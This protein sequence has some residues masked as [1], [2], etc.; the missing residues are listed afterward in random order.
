MRIPK[1]DTSAV[2]IDVQEKLFP[3]IHEKEALLKKL[4]TLIKGVSL[5]HIPLQVTEQYPE[6]LGATIP[7][8]DK[9]LEGIKMSSKKCFSCHDSM[10]FKKQLHFNGNKYVLLAGIEAHVC[11]L[12]TAIDLKAAGYEPVVIADAVAS[13]SP[14]DKEIAMNRFTQERIMISTVESILLELCRTS[15]HEVFRDISKLIK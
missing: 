10:S 1:N 5:L 9:L 15:T 4:E 6:G 14:Y 12:Q 13:R 3:H 7:Q 11:V 2:I 8:L